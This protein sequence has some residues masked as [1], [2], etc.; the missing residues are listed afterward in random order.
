M[1]FNHRGG[2]TAV[3]AF[4]MRQ[5]VSSHMSAVRGAGSLVLGL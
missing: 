1:L 2:C 5:K 4:L 3:G